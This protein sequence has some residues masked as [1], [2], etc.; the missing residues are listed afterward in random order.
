MILLFVGDMAIVGNTPN[1]LQQILIFYIYILVDGGIEANT[2][3]TKIMISGERE[4]LKREENKLTI[5][6]LIMI[7]LLCTMNIYLKKHLKR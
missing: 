1:E 5:Q 4:R 2:S 3:K 7:T 6:V